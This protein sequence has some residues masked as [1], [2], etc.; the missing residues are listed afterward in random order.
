MLRTI[1]ELDANQTEEERNIHGT[2]EVYL[3]YNGAPDPNDDPV[4]Y[5]YTGEMKGT[6]IA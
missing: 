1:T 4:E 3:D 2:L 5:C 6:I